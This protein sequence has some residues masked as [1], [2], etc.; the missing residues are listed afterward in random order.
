MNTKANTNG[1]GGTFPLQTEISA[2]YISKVIRKVQSQGYKYIYPSQEATDEFNEVITSFFDDKTIND[3]C[4]GWWKSGFGKSRPLL[5]WPGTGHHRFDISRDPRWEDFVFERFDEGR[6]NRFEY[7]GNGYTE[8]E[9]SADEI[10]LTNYIKQGGRIDD[11]GLATL[12][13]NWND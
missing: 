10:S 3:E 5:S 6:R 9:E 4:D 11:R 2:T 1:Q 7:F 12:H 8:R 13:E